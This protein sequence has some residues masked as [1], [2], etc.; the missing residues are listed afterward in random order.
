VSGDFP[1]SMLGC[2]AQ[3]AS[4]TLRQISTQ[5]ANPTAW[6]PLTPRALA[7]GVGGGGGEG[8]DRA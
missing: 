7:G 4:P 8:E 1:W 6:L 5:N 3:P 2:A